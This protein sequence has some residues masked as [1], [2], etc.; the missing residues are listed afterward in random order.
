MSYFAFTFYA[1]ILNYA[2]V[3]NF[4]DEDRPVLRLILTGES[5]RMRRQQIRVSIH[6]SFLSWIL[7]FILGIVIIVILSLSF[8]YHN[9]WKVNL[10]V[11]EYFAF[12]DCP[13][14]F[15]VLPCVYIM[16]GKKIKEIIVSRNWW[17]GIRSTFLR[18]V[19]LAPSGEPDPPSR[20]PDASVQTRSRAS[21]QERPERIPEGEQQKED[22]PEPPT[23]S[24]IPAR[25]SDIQPSAMSSNRLNST[26]TFQNRL[27]KNEVIPLSNIRVIQVESIRK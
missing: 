12:F 25:L 8:L 23:P 6:I 17:Q 14:L 10:N 11:H 3:L 19:Q 21:N 4:R 9:R 18:S 24:T 27:A 1:T 7:E 2:C 20:P 16:N 22:S 5:R 26:A 15:I 13:G